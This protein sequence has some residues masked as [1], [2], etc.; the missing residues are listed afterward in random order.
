MSASRKILE[1]KGEEEEEWE[2]EESWV[3]NFLIFLYEKI[4]SIFFSNSI[5]DRANLSILNLSLKHA[6]NK[7]YV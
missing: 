5:N 7:K 2:G 1:E 6:N 3:M 4:E